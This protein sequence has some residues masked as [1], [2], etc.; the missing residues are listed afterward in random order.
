MNNALPQP[1]RERFASGVTRSTAYRLRQLRALRKAIVDNRQKILTALNSDLR[2]CECEALLS[3]Y[4]P[5]LSSIRFMMR[6]LYSFMRPQRTSLSFFN[7]PGSGY[8][9]AEPYGT[10]LI[11][12]T[13]N[14]PFLLTMDALIAA[15]AAGNT[16]VIKL[17]ENSPL[18][19]E[20]IQTIVRAALPEDVAAVTWLDTEELL[21]QRY[22]MVYF[23]GSPEG[24][25]RILAKTA[26]FLTPTVLELGGKNPAIVTED[27]D[28]YRAA[29]RLVWGKFLNA[30]QTCTAPD[31]LL[32][33]RS[34]VAELTRHMRNAIREFYGDNPQ[35]SD[36]F[37][38][39][40]TP[41]HYGRLCKLL[42]DGRLLAGG[43]KEPEERYIAPTILDSVDFDTSAVMQQEI[44]GPILP[45]FCFDT[46]DEVV[47]KI[48]KLPKPLAIYL[49]S[50]K[51]K[52]KKYFERTTSSGSFVVNDC[53]VQT[54][55]LHLPFGGVGD[56]GFGCCHGKYGFEAF[57]HRKSVLS[58]NPF[59]DWPFRYPPY[60]LWKTKII[61]FLSK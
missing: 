14:F 22:D 45:V 2:K 36:H 28:L 19:S 23:I 59:F 54:P 48:Q 24:G 47:Q 44:F 52:I 4:R 8:T 9:I 21:N 37:G 60:G 18:T 29:R 43:E 51:R 26:Q 25:R 33:H 16:V 53:V 27:A 10:V 61:R 35:E 50:E 58:K 38:R 20:V 42:T 57:S 3:E 56:S 55:E 32:A 5:V 7:R 13:W 34:V 49:F 30:G 15:I 11:S 17:S 1:Q 31:Y 40:I 12:S 6:R 41:A 39:I 46:L